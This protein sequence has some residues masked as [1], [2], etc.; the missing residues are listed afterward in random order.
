MSLPSKASLEICRFCSIHSLTD[1]SLWWFCVIGT[2]CLFLDPFIIVEEHKWLHS[3]PCFH[4]QVV[5]EVVIHLA[6]SLILL[7]G[8]FPCQEAPAW[9]PAHQPYLAP[10]YWRPTA[11]ALALRVGG[12][13]GWQALAQI[14]FGKSCCPHTSLSEVLTSVQNITGLR[15]RSLPLVAC[16]PVQKFWL[17]YGLKVYLYI[18][19]SSTEFLQIFMLQFNVINP[20]NHD[21]AS[22]FLRPVL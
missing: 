18:W 3:G 9:P 8:G 10:A 16:R 4:C 11:H 5:G 20:E 1:R 7:W 14:H 15:I 12:R 19:E 2:F 21:K 13:A 6:A 17:Q 22:C